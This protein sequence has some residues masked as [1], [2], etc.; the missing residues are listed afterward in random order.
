MISDTQNLPY[1]LTT[2][3]A[4][5]TQEIGAR[6]AQFLQPGYIVL[7]EGNLGAGKTTF[8]KG[9]ARGLGID[10]Y[11]NSPTF[12]LVNEYA[13]RLPLYHMDCYRLENGQEAIAFGI[14]EYLYGDGVCVIEWY[15]RIADIL[16]AEWLKIRLAHVTEDERQLSFEANGTRFS[17]LLENFRHNK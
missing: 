4:A 12:T 11:V 5:E 6:L 13:G 3:S 15:E 17:E 16:P 9:L 14:E 1:E 2:R 10:G 8:T 7:L